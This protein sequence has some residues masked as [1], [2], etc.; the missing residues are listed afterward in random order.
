MYNNGQTYLWVPSM[1]TL[2]TLTP[3]AV[4]VV[5]G[6]HAAIGKPSVTVDSLN[7]YYF[8][9]NDLDMGGAPFTRD[10]TPGMAVCGPIANLSYMPLSYVAL[11]CAFGGDVE[12]LPVFFEIADIKADCPFSTTT[13]KETWETWG[14]FGESHKPRK[15]GA[16]WYRSSDV[17]ESG[18]KMLASQWVGYMQAGGT[19]L[20]VTQYQALQ[21][22]G[23]P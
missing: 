4:T 15:I 8:V 14:T 7:P 19:V 5:N 22:E 11:I 20:T 21:P 18:Q 6:V 23:I 16:K 12:G 17:G 2:S 9:L 13:P 3:E 1:L 10:A